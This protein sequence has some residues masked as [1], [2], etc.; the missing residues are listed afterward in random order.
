MTTAATI[1]LK[2]LTVDARLLGATPVV[3]AVAVTGARYQLRHAFT[4]LAA[5][6]RVA[7]KV[8]AR[9]SIDPALWDICGVQPG[10]RADAY[11]AAKGH[12]EASRA[13]AAREARLAA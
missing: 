13:E 3:I 10:S 9:R 4:N 11:L 6:E 5:A 2:V 7:D 1:R 12:I 8:A